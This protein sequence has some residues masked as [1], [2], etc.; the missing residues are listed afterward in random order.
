VRVALSISGELRCFSHPIIVERFNEYIFHDLKPDIFISTWDHIGISH[1]NGP[2]YR[3]FLPKN[4]DIEDIYNVYGNIK[5]LDIENFE[6][7]T[8]D[9]GG[10]VLVQHYLDWKNRGFPDYNC[11]SSV[12]Q[13]YK[14]Y[15]SYIDISNYETNN[16]FEYDIIIKLRPDLF[17]SNKI[18][19]NIE[20]NTIYN[21]NF[22]PG[23][24]YHP[25]RVYD[26]FFYSDSK[27]FKHF[28]ETWLRLESLFNDSWSDGRGNLDATKNLFLQAERNNV[29]IKSVKRRVCEIYRGENP[30]EF[31]RRLTEHDE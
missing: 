13:F 7:W 25:N 29:K 21:Q 30:D 23:G 2:E 31:H 17:Y 8:K 18:E 6:S 3:N 22:G 12:P 28:G 1:H 15:K 20:S 27:T 14:L 10:E 11:A 19:K 4:F 26:I 16:N 5:S 9:N 24:W